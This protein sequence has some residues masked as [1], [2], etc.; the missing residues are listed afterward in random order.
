MQIWD[1][2]LGRSRGHA[3]SGLLE[4]EYSV[5]EAG[6]VIKSYSELLKDTSYTN[7]KM[8]RELYDVNYSVVHDNIASVN[9]SL[10][11][12]NCTCY[13]NIINPGVYL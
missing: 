5:N 7:T 1:F 6:F 9:V 10:S 13:L 11:D 2:H 4:V 12:L 3:E 8:S